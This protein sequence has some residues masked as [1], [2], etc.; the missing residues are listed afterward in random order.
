MRIYA[1]TQPDARAVF[2]QQQHIH[3]V[4]THIKT[5]RNTIIT[6]IIGIEVKNP[7]GDF[8]AGS[9]SDC[10]TVLLFT[11]DEAAKYVS[12]GTR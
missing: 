4:S 9:L 7:G 12:L 10:L 6:A 1:F 5:S 3:P 2:N 8:G 11:D